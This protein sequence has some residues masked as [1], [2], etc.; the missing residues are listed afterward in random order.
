MIMVMIRLEIFN[1]TSERLQRGSV[2]FGRLDFG[3][4]K[5]NGGDRV[6]EEFAHDRRYLQVNTLIGGNGER[7]AG[8]HKQNWAT[9]SGSLLYQSH[10][11]ME[12]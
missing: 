2:M 1:R 12:G 3:A 10:C 8:Y 7:D 11:L 6:L 9:Q 5:K 4:S